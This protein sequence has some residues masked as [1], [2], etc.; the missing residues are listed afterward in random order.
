[1][2][3][4]L[5]LLHPNISS[6]S[7][8]CQQYTNIT[9]T[10][11]IS[12]QCNYESLI[13]DTSWFTIP[14]MYRHAV[15]LHLILYNCP[16][17]VN[18][19]SYIHTIVQRPSCYAVT[20]IN[21]LQQHTLKNKLVIF[22]EGKGYRTHVPLK[23]ELIIYWCSLGVDRAMFCQLISMSETK[24]SHLHFIRALLRTLQS[25]ASLNIVWNISR[26]HSLHKESHTAMLMTTS[27]IRCLYSTYVGHARDQGHIIAI[28][29][30]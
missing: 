19:S 23:R 20:L 16:S 11:M 15:S 22:R 30:N 17:V 21:L 13:V 25:V 8:I 9:R 24:H 5:P 18:S 14:Y 2:S 26:T 27:W 1:M 29:A 3:L 28:S 4:L 7:R 10:S 6:S 12:A